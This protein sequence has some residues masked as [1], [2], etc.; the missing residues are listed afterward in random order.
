[1]NILMA[2]NKYLIPGG[3]DESFIAESRMLR[4]AGHEVTTFSVHNSKLDEMSGPR[5]AIAT[6]WSQETYRSVRTLLR[7]SDAQV[8]HVQNFFP[9]ISPSIY[10]AARAEGVPV[11]QSLRN[12]RLLCPNGLFFRD[13]RPCEDC[14]NKPVQL[15]G[16]IH[17]C[18]RGS[19]QA[20]A[21]VAAM[22]G[23]HR[24]VGTWSRMVQIYIALTN[25]ARD[26]YVDGGWPTDK[27]V[28]KPNFVHPDP[29]VGSQTRDGMMFVGRL[30]PEK[31]LAT[32]LAAWEHLG[33]RGLSL[34]IVGDGPMRNTVSEAASRIPG[35]SYLG[36]RSHADMLELVGTARALIVPS[37]WYETFGRVVVEA[38]AKG[39]PVIASRIG[40]IAEIVEE[41]NT[42][43]LFEPGNAQELIEAVQ[44]AERQPE[45]WSE[46]GARARSRFET[47]YMA[48]QNCQ[49]LI[50]IY[51]QAG[52]VE[53][54]RETEATQ[55]TISAPRHAGY[56]TDEE[57][58][59][60]RT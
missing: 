21:V 53:T 47:R 4:D 11:V 39:T 38:Y 20:S 2:H 45:A 24:L 22:N 52:A 58:G 41:E 46:M 29:G 55:N 25:F 56:P 12:Y 3:E 18:Y 32:L 40:A 14:L 27:I 6:I 44:R 31:G 9:L 16:V 43:L 50:A 35:V 33:P 23:S 54:A 48:E 1:M 51:A 5:K 8:L 17:R 42:G 60:T 10:Y 7:N 36:S 49:H 13:G 59:R 28:V 37:E 26:K 19:R 30:S 57:G 34:R 15:P